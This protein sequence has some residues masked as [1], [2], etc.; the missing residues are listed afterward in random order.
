M[1]PTPPE[2]APIPD[3][4]QPP[5]PAVVDLAA[6]PPLPE[7]APESD[8]APEPK[9]DCGP[10]LIAR[11]PALFGGPHPK[12]VKL[13][14]QTDIQAAAP[15]VFSKAQLTAFFRRHT[16]TT[17]YLIALTREPHR[18]D[19]EG[20]PAGE[21]AAEHREAAEAELAVRRARRDEKRAAEQAAYRQRIDWL[22]A[23]DK[24]SVDELAAAH[25]LS[26][27]QMQAALAQ[28]RTEAEQRAQR[29][30]ANPPPPRPP[31]RDGAPRRDHG[32][33]PPQAERPNERPSERTA[34][35]GRAPE[36]DRP[37]RP[38]RDSQRPPRRD[39]GPRG[40][41]P[42]ADRGAPR[43]GAPAPRPAPQAPGQS[44]MQQAWLAAL[45]GKQGDDKS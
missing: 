23:S 33:R 38:P 28:A 27:A 25:N 9:A 15:D 2:T 21:I 3:A 12:P 35:R 11:F 30:A 34:E 22:R 10:A 32:P 29:R 24:Q 39:H 43:P 17:A 19:L 16:R 7:A 41:A 5:E 6:T 31:R 1:N 20:Q 42:R 37:R 4:P 8:T 18:Y 36:G 45:S 26:P 13:H 44:A 14:I 40:D